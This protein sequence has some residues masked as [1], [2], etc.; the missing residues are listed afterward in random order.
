MK[1]IAYQ[2]ADGSV[3]IIGVN[4]NKRARDM[5]AAEARHAEKMRQWA[6]RMAAAT[7]AKDQAGLGE[8]APAIQR[9]TEE[10][11][12]AEIAAKSV[13]AGLTWVIVESEDLPKRADLKQDGSGDIE[14]DHRRNWKM[15]GRRVVIGA[16]A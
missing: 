7:A 15:E 6:A 8:P 2:K 11:W 13:P 16:R 1:V 4:R 10:E 12:L 14:T 5:A 9:S 3:G